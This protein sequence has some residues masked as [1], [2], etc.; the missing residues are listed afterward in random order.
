[1]HSDRRPVIIGAGPAG[2]TAALELAKNGVAAQVF[3]ASSNVG[4]LARTPGEHG[5]R[6]DPGGHRFF[7]KNEHILQL[8]KSLLPAGEWHA[9]SRRSAMLVDGHYVPYPLLGRNLLTQLG[10]GRGA[11]GLGSLLWSRMRRGMRSLDDSATF[12]E[13]GRYQF[14]D[15][16]YRMFF[17]GYVRKTWLAE[18]AQLTSDW[19]EQRI[20]PIVWGGRDAMAAD[21]FLYPRRGPGQLW[22]AAA[23]ELARFGVEPSLDSPVVKLRFDGRRW[24]IELRN[25]DTVTGDAVF[26]S[27]P[28]QMLVN[29]LEPAPPQQVWEAA[30]QLKHRGLITVAV[31][32]GER[33][34]LPF[35]WVYTPGMDLQVG[36][37]QNYRQWS[38]DLTP[39]GWDGTY[40]GFEY[41]IGA[42]S[43]LWTADD[44]HM[45][46]RVESDLRTLGFDP[47]TIERVMVVRSQFAYPICNPAMESSVAQIRDCLR[48]QYPS[49]HPIGRNGMHRYDNQDHAMLSA[50]HSVK[51]YFGES[52]DP[53]QVNKER[54]Y[55]ESGLLKV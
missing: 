2:L 55:H 28:L 15:Y 4:G 43:A 25:G 52:V 9:V 10:Y 12:L 1:M 32:L 16:W 7:T 24:V 27:M 19:A 31:A 18:P 3:E 36:R 46:R 14:G 6:V 42:G 53:W 17:D 47:S 5:F 40:L 49:L 22:D 35:N 45:R 51:R 33:R 21:A 41:F 50:M 54:R 38:D 37:I 23:S 30:A 20:K 44:A 48:R 34:E 11:R 8:W 13:W 39:P 29:A 26:S